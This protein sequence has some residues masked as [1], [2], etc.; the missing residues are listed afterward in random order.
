M[1]MSDAT[2]RAIAMLEQQ[3]V[4]LAGIRNATARDPSFKNW[5][6]STLTTMQRIWPGDQARSE[7]FRRIPFSPADPRADLRAMREQ[8]SRGCQEAGRVLSSFMEELV[9]HGA[10]ELSGEALPMAPES[11]FEDGFPTLDLPT[12]EVAA[13]TDPA[14]LAENLLAGLG[15][16]TPQG[17]DPLFEAPRLPVSP[18][19]TPATPATPVQKKSPGMKSRLRDLLGFAQLSAKTLAG[20]PRDNA[21]P[22]PPAPPT[23]SAQSVQPSL[24]G[25][26]PLGEGVGAVPPQASPTADSGPSDVPADWPLLPRRAPVETLPPAE[27]TPWSQTLSSVAAAASNASH[28]VMPVVTPDTVPPTVG[29]PPIAPTSVAAPPT[30]LEPAPGAARSEGTDESRSVTMSRPTTLRGNIDKVSIESLISAE[31][32][33]HDAPENEAASSGVSA[34]NEEPAVHLRLV[35]DSTPAATDEVEEVDLPEP[36][37]EPTPAKRPS[38]ALVRPLLDDPEFNV[39]PTPSQQ[40]RPPSPDA[41]VSELTRK[42]VR[43]AGKSAP[44]APAQPVAPPAVADGIADIGGIGDPHP[45]DQ[46]E[47]SAR[48]TNARV[49]PE[50][51]ARATDEFMRSSP[52][53]GASP[54]RAGRTAQELPDFGDA[55]AIAVSSMAQ[56]LTRME[57]PKERHAE[58]RAR[59]MDLARRLER[60]ELEWSALRKAVWFAMEYPELARRLMPVLLPW[61]DRAA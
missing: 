52:V 38:L 48:A 8:Y 46:D 27:Q 58:V 47:A 31:F 19:T 17:R 57:V 18:P 21:A 37:P 12:G 33:A 42:P 39:D 40:L 9:Q 29:S 16:E 30:P 53:L 6:Q 22:S 51:S 11:D 15:E 56:D 3:I 55:D 25:M 60:G 2:Q 34:A 26:T 61:I 14:R 7:R 32:R 4:D 43:A 23:L 41:P 5:R 35:P 50:E 20:F 45:I 54:R 44:V 36:Q 24:E 1:S 13:P 10:P 49:D 59:L 28:D